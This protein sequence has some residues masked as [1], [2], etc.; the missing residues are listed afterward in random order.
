MNQQTQDKF[1]PYREAMAADDTW[2]V[3]LEA[4]FGNAA[5]TMRYKPEGKAGDLAPLAAAKRAADE[6]W[7]AA[8]REMR[9]NA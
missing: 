7:L 6:V 8:M 2:Q 9:S 5:G 4:K 3:A 1:K